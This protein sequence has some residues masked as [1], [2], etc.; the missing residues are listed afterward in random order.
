[1]NK[2][3]EYESIMAGL[4]EALEESQSGNS[5]LKRDIVS[6]ESVKESEDAFG[7]WNDSDI[8]ADSIRKQAW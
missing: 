8:S 3:S 1:M 4:N 5:I 7:M 2:K 6:I